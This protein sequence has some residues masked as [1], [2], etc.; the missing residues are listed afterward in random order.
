MYTY[1]EP[2]VGLALSRELYY[3]EFSKFIYD[4][5]DEYDYRSSSEF[6]GTDID[7]FLQEGD[8]KSTVSDEEIEIAKLYFDWISQNSEYLDFNTAYHGS[9]YS[10]KYLFY[11]EAER[12]QSNDTETYSWSKGYLKN[13]YNDVEKFN[14][15]CKES[16]PEKLYKFLSERNYLGL[17]F[18]SMSS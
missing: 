9:S 13:I 18:V 10:A 12:I 1:H 17:Q 7:E 5:A 4:V 6:S 15:F 16:M 14:T 11:S 2:L 3:S 8:L